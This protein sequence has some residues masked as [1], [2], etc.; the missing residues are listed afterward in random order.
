M[1]QLHTIKTTTAD[2][3]L[4]QIPDPAVSLRLL[5]DV[6]GVHPDDSLLDQPRR[7]LN[8]SHWVL[9]LTHEQG[10]DGGW[11][12]LHSQN[13]ALRR[14]IPTTE[15][16]V[17]RALALG[18]DAGHPILA[19]AAD[20]LVAL[21]E[22]RL[23]F[24]DPAERNDRW[25]TAKRLFTAATLASI[26]PNHPA[27]DETWA[28]WLEI[29]ERTFARGDYDAQAEAEAHRRLSGASVQNS[30]L[31][32]ANRYSLAL[33]GARANQIP[34]ATE[35]ALL[36]WLWH[37]PHGIGYL[38]V[39]LCAQPENFSSSQ[40]DRWF[41]SHELLAAFPSWR[42]LAGSSI[43]WLCEQQRPDGLWNFGPSSRMSHYFPLSESW[44][45]KNSRAFDWSARTLILLSRFLEQ[46]SLKLDQCDDVKWKTRPR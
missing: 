22:A 5:R 3:I 43:R 6:L 37:K 12:R 31:V 28:L 35:N 21:L 36:N 1:S 16:A 42:K 32:I 30:H 29:S 19:R 24:P 38:G 40:L 23:P 44:R 39:S 27:L 8:G 18:L 20:Y 17:N 4:D 2:R 7:E 46:R 33:L 11:G 41:A 14:P 45:K 25:E 34:H 10:S 9:Q 15:F 13:S 26:H